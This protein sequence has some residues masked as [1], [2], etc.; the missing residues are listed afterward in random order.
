MIINYK[1]LSKTLSTVLRHR[2]QLLG[3]NLDEQGWTALPFLI[4]ALRRQRT[5]WVDLDEQIIQDMMEQASKQRFEIKE[6]K[7]R[8]IYGHSITQRI[9]KVATKPPEILYHGTPRKFVKPIR[10][11]GLKPMKRQYVH[12]SADTKTATIVGKRRDQYPVILEVLA[13]EAYQNGILFYEETN[14]IWLSAAIP[15]R[16]IDFGD[17]G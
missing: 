11:E 15:S 10:K 12:L 4:R 7:I 3:I 6:N 1:K 9:E 17:K 2:P 5:E 14:G 16:F 8:A 13:L